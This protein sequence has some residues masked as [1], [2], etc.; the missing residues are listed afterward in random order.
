M[1]LEQAAAEFES[2]FIVHPEVGCPNADYEGPLDMSRAPTGEPYAT[3]LSGAQ[4]RD[5][6]AVP[7]WYTDITMAAQDWIDMARH[8]ANGGASGEPLG[9]HLYW[10]DKPRWVEAE[11]VPVDQAAAMNDAVLRIFTPMKIGFIYS[12]FVVSTM[13]PSGKEDGDE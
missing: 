13:D 6:E 2:S 4:A 11:F 8:Y 9:T 10:R 3:I 1:T 12:R 5:G 7:I